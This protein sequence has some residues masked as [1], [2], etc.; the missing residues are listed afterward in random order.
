MCSPAIVFIILKISHVFPRYRSIAGKHIKNC[1]QT[2]KFRGFLQNLF[3]RFS[4]L[5]VPQSTYIPRE[6]QCLSPRPKWDSPPLSCEQFDGVGGPNSDDWRKGLA[7]CLL[8]GLSKIRE[9]IHI[10]KGIKIGRDYRCILPVLRKNHTCV[11]PVS[12]FWRRWPHDPVRTHEK[13]F[14]RS[15]TFFAI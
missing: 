15:N 10:K 3:G 8:C 4:S 1:P 2:L 13:L 6:P 11:I 7:L 9:N 14:N 5:A 12:N